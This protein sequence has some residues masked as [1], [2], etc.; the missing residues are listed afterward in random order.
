MTLCHHTCMSY[1]IVIPWPQVYTFL[2]VGGQNIQSTHWKPNNTNYL[3]LLQLLSTKHFKAHHYPLSL[4]I[5]KVLPGDEA[6]THLLLIMNMCLN[7]RAS[8]SSSSVSSNY[9]I[10]LTYSSNLKFIVPSIIWPVNFHASLMN[11]Q[12]KTHRDQS[13]KF[14]CSTHLQVIELGNFVR[15]F[16]FK[17]MIS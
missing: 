17:V 12:K 7:F 4:F 5:L 1:A 15:I 2:G 16:C 9:Y 14:K 3:R 8:V 13:P 11:A 10:K 6:G